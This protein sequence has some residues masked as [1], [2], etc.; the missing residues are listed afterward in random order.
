MKYV[1][2]KTTVPVPSVISWNSDASNEVGAEYMF[3]SKVFRAS[4]EVIAL[5]HIYLQVSGVSAD[6]VWSDLP[7]DLKKNT[8]RQVA[9]CIF[10]LWQLRFNALGSLYFA[11][12]G[13]DYI[14]GP[15][16]ETHFL[17]TIDVVPR[18][19]DPID[20]NEFRG[21]FSSISAYLA[22]GL[23][24]E[25]KLYAERRE[26]LIAADDGEAERIE[27]GRNAMEKALELCEIYP[28]DRPIS[29][30]LKEPI[31]LRLDDFRLSTW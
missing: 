1:A 6:S 26:D 17:R 29:D 24:S 15:V 22:S 16:V 27:S 30:D 10:K 18:V 20:L 14:V 5:I 7:I 19:K 13:N 21:P 4:F 28:G 23:R 12:D 31:S 11:D 2:E 3:I 9:G 8:V 25:L